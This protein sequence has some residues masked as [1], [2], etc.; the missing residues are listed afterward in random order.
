[1]R[2]TFFKANRTLRVRSL[3]PSR[4]DTLDT[5][6]DQAS[7]PEAEEL[8]RHVA[9]H[10]RSVTES[11]GRSSRIELS[12]RAVLAVSCERRQDD[13]VGAIGHRTHRSNSRRRRPPTAISVINGRAADSPQ[14]MPRGSTRP[15]EPE[16]RGT[17]EFGRRSGRG[18]TRGNEIGAS[19]TMSVVPL[20]SPHCSHPPSP[21]RESPGGISTS[22]MTQ[23]CSGQL[24]IAGGGQ[25]LAVFPL[26]SWR[27]TIVFP[28]FWRH[29]NA[30]AVAT[31][32]IT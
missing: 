9:G 17:V 28:R 1:M 10:A 21:T 29:R 11:V 18:P 20:R 32:I 13:G 3:P 5:S 14:S 6:G 16:R 2:S 30:A 15:L 27:I 7:A 4:R 23:S 26:L 22:A 25:S 12:I 8:R 24:I 31:F 19:I